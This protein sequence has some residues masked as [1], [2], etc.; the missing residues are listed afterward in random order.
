MSKTEHKPSH[1]REAVN[2]YGNKIVIPVID[3][4]DGIA[5]RMIGMNM[6]KSN[7]RSKWIVYNQYASSYKKNNI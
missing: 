3:V 7:N 1:Y 5:E 2:K 6:I 4:R